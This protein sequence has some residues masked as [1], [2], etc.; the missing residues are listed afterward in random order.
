MSSR[1][2]DLLT[3]AERRIIELEAELADLRRDNAAYREFVAEVLIQANG[4]AE[5]GD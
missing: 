3:I 2:D 5:N 4:G 1:A